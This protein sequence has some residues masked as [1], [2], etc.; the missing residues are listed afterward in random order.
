MW[1]EERKESLAIGMSNSSEVPSFLSRAG[2]DADSIKEMED[3]LKQA[4]SDSKTSRA[5]GKHCLA[6]L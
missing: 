4:E 3:A 2:S 5:A 6:A 1:A